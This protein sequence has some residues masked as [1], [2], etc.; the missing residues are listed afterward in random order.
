M[1][2]QST[3]APCETPV[4]RAATVFDDRIDARPASG[5]ASRYCLLMGCV[6]LA[7]VSA[8]GASSA[9]SDAA[10]TG[11]TLT[12]DAVD[13]DEGLLDAQQVPADAAS[14]TPVL[15]DGADGAAACVVQSVPDPDVVA[16]DR[17][18]VRGSRDVDVRLF[19]GVP[20]AAPPTGVRRFAPPQPSACWAD[21]RDATRFGAVCPQLNAQG[22][23]IGDEDCLTLNVYAPAIRPANPLPVLF[24]I[25]G[26]ANT[27]GSASVGAEFNQGRGLYDGR[28]LVR[29]GAVVVTIQYRLGALGFL[30]HALLNAENPSAPSGNQGLRDQIQALRWVQQN[31][32]AFGGDPRRVLLFGES[33]GAL[34]ALLLTAS[35][36]TA[37][38]FSRVLSQSGG[39]GA[40][41]T[42]TARAAADRLLMSASCAA[43]PDPIACL[44]AKTAAEVLLARPA[45]GDGLVGSEFGPSIDGDVIAQPPLESVRLG[46]HQRVPMVIG[47]NSEETARMIP[48]PAMVPTA[49]EFDRLARAYLAQYRLTP[50]QTDAVV[51][52]YNPMMFASPWRALQVLTT[53]TRWTCPTRSVIRTAVGAQREAVY[54]YYFT[55]R[56]DAR[57]A[58]SQSAFG[59]Y[60]ALELFYVFGTVDGFAGY[61][62][63]NEDRAV[64]DSM[65][66]YWTRFAATGDPNG[67]MSVR[68]PAYTAM[69]DAFLQI[70]EPPTA[71]DGIQTA[72]CDALSAIV[73]G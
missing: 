62:A 32:S 65:Q 27:Q 9:G 61:R 21:V 8:C 59:A 7:T 5:R 35:P 68:W 25:H 4:I 52:L 40:A 33:A 14:D 54:R 17:G 16:T 63:S 66:G 24:F 31:I 28:S 26:G 44:R 34:D 3:T 13:R 58:P 38:L 1:K 20:Y 48:L 67:A 36:R 50:A 39:L 46:M 19:L 49:A 15:T 56:L 30:S 11:D 10:V 45:A 22:M 60:H 2:T 53:E 70:A 23:P 43:S 69:G 18:N 73:G 42:D 57:V 41:P 37:G 6:L 71:G 12:Q 47:S 64:V 29:R 55:H 51:A 72:R